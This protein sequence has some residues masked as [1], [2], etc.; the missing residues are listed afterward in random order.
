MP[1]DAQVEQA[2]FD[3]PP[4]QEGEPQIAPQVLPEQLP[5]EGLRAD[6]TSMSPAVSLPGAYGG[7]SAGQ[8]SHEL[9]GRPQSSSA[10]TTA[11]RSAIELLQED[12]LRDALYSLSAWVG[13]PDLTPE[14]D[15]RLTR[16][17]D[18]LAGTV[19]FS[20]QHLMEPAYVVRRDE[21]LQDIAASFHVPWQLL[22]YINGISNPEVLIPGQRLKVIRGPFTA[23]VDLER[24]EIVLYLRGHYAGRFPFSQGRDQ[25][26]RPGTY[27]VVS[28]MVERSAYDERNQEIPPGDP[29]SPYGGYWIDLGSNQSIH[30]IAPAGPGRGCIALAPRDAQDLFAVLSLGSQVA[31]R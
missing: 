29:N 9:P 10:F 4:L 6:A 14:E 30:A 15:S 28:K 26:P 31:I 12:R 25:P 20:K 17:L 5:E 3:A 11:W 23:R 7:R 24:Q 13:S 27:Q 18:E 22:A 8:G 1:S 16:L 21:E 2:G 19:I